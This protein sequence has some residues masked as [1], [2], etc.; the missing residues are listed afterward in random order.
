MTILMIIIVS[1][2]IVSCGGNNDEPETK[3]VSIVG[4]WKYDDSEG[5]WIISFNED[6][7]GYSME[8]KYSK[9]S[10]YTNNFKWV[11]DENSKTLFL[12]YYDEETK[13]Y[14]DREAYSVASLTENKL[15]LDYGNGFITFVRQ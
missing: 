11:L 12:S 7:T 2:T 8:E 1:V 14:T 3:K 9:N 4:T 13:D 15:G 10:P 5:Y 6:G